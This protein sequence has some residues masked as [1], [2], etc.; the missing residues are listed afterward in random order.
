MTAIA[1][2]AAA[3]QRVRS[4]H[5]GFHCH[6]LE[7]LRGRCTRAAVVSLLQG[8][9][10]SQSTNCT[11]TQSPVCT[12][13]TAL[14]EWLSEY[15]VRAY[16]TADSAV[17]YLTKHRSHRLQR[18]NSTN[19]SWVWFKTNYCIGP[20]RLPQT[21]LDGIRPTE[22][23]GC[24]GLGVEVTFKLSKAVQCSRCVVSQSYPTNTQ[25]ITVTCHTLRWNWAAK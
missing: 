23:I 2:S 3:N 6:G 10:A 4:H 1:N 20:H 14:L 15:T 7:T 12:G 5:V 17:S 11:T 16:T 9:S 18:R 19:A 8:A 21:G 13:Y 22:P 25:T 24:L